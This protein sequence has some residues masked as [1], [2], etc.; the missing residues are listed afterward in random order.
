MSPVRFKYLKDVNGN[1]IGAIAYRMNSNNPCTVSFGLSVSNPEPY[2]LLVRKEIKKWNPETKKVEG[3]GEFEEIIRKGAKDSFIKKEARRL[4]LE[5]LENVPTT[6]SLYNHSNPVMDVLRYLNEH[7]EINLSK[8]KKTI[9]SSR[10][11]AAARRAQKAMIL[12]STQKRSSLAA[13]YKF[14]F[15]KTWHKMR[16]MLSSFI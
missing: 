16:E 3:T 11:R 12:A 7:H 4:A 10:I 13:T 8:D 5:R 9:I 6:V 2:D 1:P 14:V 15:R